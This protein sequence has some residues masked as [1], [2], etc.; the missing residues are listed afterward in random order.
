MTYSDFDN[1]PRGNFRSARDIYGADMGIDA[2]SRALRGATVGRLLSALRRGLKTT[3]QTYVRGL[4]YSEY[5][6]F[7][8]F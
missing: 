7:R 5:Y 6:V 3:L 8:P 4:S 1:E 2:R